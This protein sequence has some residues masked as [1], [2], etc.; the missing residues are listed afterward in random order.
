MA[1]IQRRFKNKVALVTGGSFGIGRASAFAFSREGA[2]V[3]I[4]DLDI[5]EGEKAVRKIKKEGGEA[6]FVKA[7]VSKGNEVKEMLKRT[8]ETYG[9]LD[10][11]HNNAG[12]LGMKA[13]TAECTEK[14]WDRVLNINLKGVWLCM[15]YEIPQM[16]K[17]GGGAIVN[18]SS[19]LG[20]KGSP[21][22]PAYVASKH[23]IVGLTKAAAIEYAKA[24]IR[25]N[26]VCPGMIKTEFVEHRL[27]SDPQMEARLSARAPAERMGT[28]E[29]VAEAVL[30][31]CSREASFT[32]GH[33][34]IVDGGWAAY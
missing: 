1:K 33:A 2:K 22:F 9:Q 31:L 12:I 32:F 15:K 28:P 4:A 29:E 34:M 30:W 3:I 21:Y 20:L 11:A 23:G 5:K 13:P 18:T 14:N 7:D 27:I 10:F 8:I 26:V 19:V 25:V 6:G 24:G 17:Q 16:L